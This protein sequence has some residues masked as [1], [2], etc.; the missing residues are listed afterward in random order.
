M[1]ITREDVKAYLR[2]L[3]YDEMVTLCNEVLQEDW[4]PRQVPMGWTFI[5]KSYG[6]RIRAI[7][8]MRRFLGSNL[9]EAL[10]AVNSFPYEVTR[11][12]FCRNDAEMF[13]ALCLENGVAFEARENLVV[14]EWDRPPVINPQAM[15]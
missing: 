4:E 12:S 14:D 13:K 6:D 15:A 9:A 3:E 7:K 5:F 10:A 2:T 8:V 11:E 1:T